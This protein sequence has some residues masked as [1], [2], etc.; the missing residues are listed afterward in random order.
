MHKWF[1]SIS[2]LLV[3]VSATTYSTLPV[4]DYIVAG[5]GGAGSLFASRLTE[6]SFQVLVLE[7][8]LNSSCYSCDNTV[9][10]VVNDLWTAQGNSL[11]TTPQTYLTRSFKQPKM[12]WPGGNTRVYQGY[13]YP[14]HPGVYQQYPGNLTLE[15][16][17]PYYN[18]YQD[19]YCNYLPQSYTGIDPINCTKYHG[20]AQGPMGISRMVAN[21]SD[22]EFFFDMLDSAS[23]LGLHH[24]NDPWNA[25]E[26][27]QSNASIF[28][29][30][31]FRIVQN[32]SDPMSP[33][34][35]ES[36]WSGYTPYSVRARSNLSYKTSTQVVRIIFRN[37][38]E[39]GDFGAVVLNGFT[40]TSDPSTQ[41]VGVIYTFKDKSYPVFAR[42]QVVLSAG[43]LGT[44]KILQHSGVGPADLLES[45]G[46][47]VVAD[48]RYVGQLVA[49]H[50]GYAVIY[51]TKKNIPINYVNFG[52]MGAML[53]TTPYA[54]HGYPDVQVQIFPVFPV[55]SLE[56]QIVGTGDLQ[57]QYPPVSV[58][59]AS[60]YGAAPILNFI[61]S[62]TDPHNRGSFNITGDQYRF[63]DQYDLGISTNPTVFATS[64]DY[65]AQKWVIDHLRQILL[66]ST[67]AFAQKWID[68]E[69]SPGIRSTDPN[70]QGQIDLQAVAR[71]MDLTYHQTGG[72]NLGLATDIN[73]VVNG[74]SGVTVC[75][76]S[77]QPHP[78]NQNPTGAMLAL[79][80]Y[81]ADKLMKNTGSG[82]LVTDTFLANQD[83]ATS[84]SANGSNGAT[85]TSANGSNGATTSQT[86]QGNNSGAIGTSTSP[87]STAS[88][89]QCLFGVTL[90]LA[91]FGL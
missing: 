46:V 50:P 29:Q 20:N 56:S 79:C 82:P 4:Y 91:L 22:S 51:K 72:M 44:P 12:S 41:A 70:V 21:L 89:A 64:E 18:K 66:N 55:E 35:R 47:P 76:N 27:T 81:V 9:L 1:V 63:T 90:A 30:Q 62:R 34:V 48:N 74:I 67:S 19:H 69:L 23:D 52:G 73:G 60:V 17:L 71:G 38:V 59:D 26:I 28:V 87:V 43:V 77:L 53:L 15:E 83:G 39:R 78:P 68:S 75:D 88:I 84:T 36:T 24:V 13:A 86:N 31:V 14:A 5:G 3:A 16:F 65:L 57:I 10:S 6:G 54:R 7:Q 45:V 37:E 8:G 25:E 2:L 49:E 32:A 61:I 42:R 85:S 80:E 11:F 40:N 33:R 58:G